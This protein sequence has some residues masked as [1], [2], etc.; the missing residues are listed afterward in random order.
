AWY[1]LAVKSRERVWGLPVVD[2]LG[3]GLV[4]PLVEAV[5]SAK[6]ELLA[7]TALFLDLRPL[8]DALLDSGW[9]I[10]R[11]PRG[12]GVHRDCFLVDAKGRVLVSTADRA[13]HATLRGRKPR[14]PSLTL[15][16]SRRARLP[17]GLVVRIV[18]GE[19]GYVEA[20]ASGRQSR[21]G[22]VR[23]ARTDWSIVVVESVER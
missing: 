18:G 20:T 19:E 5:R 2:P 7:V 16:M 3:L 13:L 22:I 15:A 4:L 10:G 9:R 14:T 1:R 8:V 21:Y 17:K 6:G 12:K 11:A 23:L